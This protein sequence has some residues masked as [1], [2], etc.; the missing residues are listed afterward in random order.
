MYC[1]HPILVKKYKEL[2]DGSHKRTADTHRVPCGKCVACLSRRRNEWTYRLTA[3]QKSC[4]YSFF[5]TLTYSD[6]NVP[7]RVVDEKPYFVFR[8]SDV[9]K[10]IKRVRYFLSKFDISCNYYL[11]SEY[12]A[13]THRPHYHALFFVYD[14]NNHYNQVAN[15]FRKEWNFGYCVVKITNPANIHYVTKYCVKS[16]QEHFNDVIDDVFTLSSKASYLGKGFE[17]KLEI[18]VSDNVRSPLVYFNG[19]QQ[20]MPRIYREKLGVGGVPVKE[21]PLYPR[22]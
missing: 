11:V 13:H 12:G 6:E 14:K 16:L 18:Q 5:V 15:L 10:Y 22:S 7:I 3:E 4:N 8:K 9:Q 17:D 19:Y 21:S 20:A 1:L 2:P